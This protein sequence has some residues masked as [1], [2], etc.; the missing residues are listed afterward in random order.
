MGNLQSAIIDY[1]KNEKIIIDSS[2]KEEPLQLDKRKALNNNCNGVFDVDGAELVHKANEAILVLKK[3]IEKAQE[4]KSK[5]EVKILDYIILLE[6]NT[7]KYIERGTEP[8]FCNITYNFS[9]KDGKL[10][11]IKPNTF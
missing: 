9:I 10:I 7:V 4:N 1:L 3:N 11:V 2:I 5:A 8:R 6:S